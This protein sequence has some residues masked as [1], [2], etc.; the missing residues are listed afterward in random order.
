[1]NAAIDQPPRHDAEALRIE[2]SE[3]NDIDCHKSNL[4]RS[5]CQKRGEYRI[6]Y[7]VLTPYFMPIWGS[8]ALLPE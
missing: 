5:H 1:M 6:A 7:S 8:L 4:T 3:I 2:I